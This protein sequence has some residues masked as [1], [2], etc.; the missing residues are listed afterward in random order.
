MADLENRLVR[1][2]TRLVK[3]QESNIQQL[4]G[5]HDAIDKLCDALNLLTEQPE[6][7]NDNDE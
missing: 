6:E 4:I 3:Y 1:I 2:E 7:G 5:I